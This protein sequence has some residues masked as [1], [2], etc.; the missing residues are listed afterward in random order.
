MH[1]YNNYDGVQVDGAQ[2]MDRQTFDRTYDNG[3][4]YNYL[5]DLSKYY[6]TGGFWNQAA[7]SFDVL[8]PETLKNP[9]EVELIKIP[10]AERT[11]TIP[12]KKTK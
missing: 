8:H 1:L 5:V 3:Y 9:I 2:T 6:K 12:V 10:E 7:H 4:T 11:S